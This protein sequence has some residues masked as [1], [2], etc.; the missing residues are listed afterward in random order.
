[1]AYQEI[2]DNLADAG[3]HFAHKELRIHTPD[4]EG[5]AANPATNLTNGKDAPANTTPAETSAPTTTTP[6]NDSQ[7][8]ILTKAAAATASAALL[9]EE[10]SRID[11][12]E[13]DGGS[14]E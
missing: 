9:A 4:D 6:D 12:A 2:R 7:P 3:I 14:D 11:Y 5:S 1:L 10:M 13:T 8:S